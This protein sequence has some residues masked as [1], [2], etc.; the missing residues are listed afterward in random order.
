M[1]FH[2]NATQGLGSKDS[3]GEVTRLVLTRL[4]L[5]VNPRFSRCGNQYRCHVSGPDALRQRSRC[6]QTPPRSTAFDARQFVDPAAQL[7]LEF[8]TLF[9]RTSTEPT[10]TV[11]INATLHDNG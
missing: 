1:L 4:L 10:S 3:Q 9:R 5:L 6:R 2:S 7:P 8:R 11:S